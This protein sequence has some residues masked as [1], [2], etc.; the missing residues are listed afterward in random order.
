M[1]I[2][3]AM[4]EL[5]LRWKMNLLVLIQLTAVFTTCIICVSMIAWQ[6]QFYTGF[7]KYLKQDGLLV[8]G[9]DFINPVNGVP[10]TDSE[11]IEQYLKSAHVVTTY[12]SEVS[13]HV[14]DYPL[15][16]HTNAMDTAIIDNYRPELTTGRWLKETDYQTDLIEAVITTNKYGLKTGDEMKAW[17]TYG[18]SLSPSG[19]RKEI[20]VRIVG[21]LALGAL[22]F[23][24]S[25]PPEQELDYRVFF[26]T[27]DLDMP[28]LFVQKTDMDAAFKQINSLEGL[29]MQEGTAFVMYNQDITKEERVFNEAYLRLSPIAALEKLSTIN[30][31]SRI[32]LKKQLLQYLPLMLGLFLLTLTSEITTR[33]ISAKLE[34]RNYAVYRLCGLGMKQCCLIS[35]TSAA[36]VAVSALLISVGGISL[37]F[38]FNLSN[39]TVI[40]IG[41]WQL[42]FCLL[43]L[44]LDISCT[45]LLP[46]CIIS[47]MTIFEMERAG[48]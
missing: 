2:K 45:S 47:K 20:T 42:L 32:F 26:Q 18:D 11:A 46:R 40:K 36:I 34:L 12:L 17:N 6:L 38:V 7:E 39:H 48:Q 15:T 19:E 5:K 9:A 43:I 21:E 1:I 3:F 30:Q 10:F 29:M 14:E 41:Y 25:A 24:S 28:Y 31:N 33:T 22:F 27:A 44:L 37:A 35:L 23:G 16:F 8:D 13:Y 4:K